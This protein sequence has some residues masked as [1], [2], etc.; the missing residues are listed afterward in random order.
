MVNDWLVLLSGAIRC[1]GGR[2]LVDCNIK[3]AVPTAAAAPLTQANNIQITRL[4]FPFRRARLLAND[5]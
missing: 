3:F 1:D 2:G 5:S 4:P